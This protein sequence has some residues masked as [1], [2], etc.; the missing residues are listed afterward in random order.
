[1][2]LF[3]AL[4]SLMLAAWMFFAVTIPF[5]KRYR[6]LGKR[7][8]VALAG[9]FLL[10]GA[11]GF[12]GA[13]LSA[14]GALNWLP[15]SF[16]WPVGYADGVVSTPDGE[17]IVP[18]IGSNRIQIYDSDWHFLRGWH[19][20]AL[21]GTF[22]LLA[23]GNDRVEVITSRGEWHITYMLHGTLI[24]R[25]NYSHASYDSFPDSGQRFAVPTHWWL[26]PFAGPFYSWTTLMLGM[27]ILAGLNFFAAER[28]PI[29]VRIFAW[30]FTL[31]ARKKTRPLRK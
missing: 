26:W 17:H 21:G 28:G 9:L 31:P 20:D 16:E 4:I 18:L 13:G 27:L 2:Q 5:N 11:I 1:V 30:K 6:Y 15:Q 22:K 3:G 23:S 8:L 19:V 24:T 25:V 10:V 7:P 12:F 29:P 14:S